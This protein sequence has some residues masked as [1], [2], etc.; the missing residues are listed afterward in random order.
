MDTKDRLRVA[1]EGIVPLDR[2]SSLWDSE[3]ANVPSDR[4]SSWGP[5]ESPMGAKD[6]LGVAG[7]ANVPLGRV[8][9]EGREVKLEVE[10]GREAMRKI[11]RRGLQ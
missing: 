1:G 11:P 9:E 4:V 3:E 7:E 2:V 6:C 8:R 10:K 5:R